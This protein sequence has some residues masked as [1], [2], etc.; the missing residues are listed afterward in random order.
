MRFYLQTKFRGNLRE[1][2]I[3][4]VDLAWNDPYLRLIVSACVDIDECLMGLDN[5]DENARCND[6]EG[7]F[8]CTCL[9]GFVGD[10]FTCSGRLCMVALLTMI[11]S[12]A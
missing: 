12:F 2:S 8:T 1:S 11:A 7:G 9:D 5:C 10:G 3:F 4:C 6:T